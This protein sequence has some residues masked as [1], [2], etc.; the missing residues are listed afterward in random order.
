MGFM[1]DYYALIS[2]GYHRRR[3]ETMLL[4]HPKNTVCGACCG[5][6][7][8]WSRNAIEWLLPIALVHLGRYL[9]EF[10]FANIWRVL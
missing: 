10:L 8:L 9:V 3:E 7:G 5:I 6:V 1:M 4:T 2:R